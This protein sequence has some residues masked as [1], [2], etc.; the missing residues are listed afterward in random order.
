MTA[1][2]PTNAMG[3]HQWIPITKLTPSPLN[4]RKHFDKTKME[5]LADSIRVQGVIQPILVRPLNGDDK[6][7]IV[8]GERR[9]RA[10]KMAALADVPAVVRELTDAQALELQVIENGQ[11]VD[12]HPLEEAE[13]YEALMKCQR[14]DGQAYTADEIA[15][16]VGKSKAYVY[17]R[18]KLTALGKK[19]QEAFYEG[20][21]DASRALLLARIPVVELQDQALGEILTEGEHWDETTNDSPMSYREAAEHVRDKY[22]LQLKSAPFKT[23]DADLVPKAG[24]CTSCP[25]RTGNQPELFGDVKSGDVC[26]DPKCFASKKEAH[27]IKLREAAKASGREVI[28]GK[29]AKKLIPHEHDDPK[30]FQPLGKE[31]WVG[32]ERKT[33][34]QVLGKDCPDSVLIENPHTGELMECVRDADAAPLLKAKVPKEDHRPHGDESWRKEQKARER[35]Q[36]LEREIRRAIYFAARDRVAAAGLGIEDVRLVTASFWDRLWHDAKK[37]VAPFWIQENKSADGKKKID[38]LDALTKRIPTMS[39]EDLIR[40]LLDCAVAGELMYA[41]YNDDRAKLLG[42]FAERHQVDAAKIRRDLT[43]AAKDEAPKKKK[44]AK[45][46]A[47]K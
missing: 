40:L 12:V 2:I 17:A 14:A 1:A 42:G 21:L 38:R 32:N 18:L 23:G 35:K 19:A 28:A 10:A 6:F 9:Y 25:K 36:K 44:A 22:M 45:K 43:A 16:K 3:H 39:G 33:V 37:I 7:E 47:K 29:E 24:A 20:K 13:G 8:A 41:G 27:T 5:E 46:S 31:M 30:G 34:K 4:H 11:R 26:T 15:A